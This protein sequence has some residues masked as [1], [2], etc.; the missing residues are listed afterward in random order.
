M[1][2]IKRYLIIG[3]I[4]LQCTIIKAQIFNK[5]KATILYGINGHPL[6]QQDYLSMSINTQCEY[7]RK[8]HLNAYRVDVLLNTKGDVLK[9][10]VRFDSL[11]NLTRKYNI[12]ILPMIYMDGIK[13]N[14]T[15]AY[16][17]Q[18]GYKTS[19]AFLKR[20]NQLN[21]IELGN[22]MNN[23]FKKEELAANKAKKNKRF[24]LM[25]AYLKGFTKGLKQLKPSLK[26]VIGF[27]FS[28]SWFLKVLDQHGV[29][30]D[31]IGNNF[32]SNIDFN[33]SG[34]AKMLKDITN[35]FDNR[36]SVWITEFNHPYGSKWA[37]AK[38][39]KNSLSLIY[40]SHKKLPLVKAVFI[41][42]LLDQPNLDVPENSSFEREFGIMSRDKS[43]R[44][45]VKDVFKNIIVN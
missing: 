36:R 43:G 34:Y 2:D 17:Y 40:N 26:T 44:P 45:Y 13:Y 42:E 11:Y 16:N 4:L 41:Y 23:W 5:S 7:L 21:Y 18:L 33:A 38:T 28:E 29:K 25:A 22:E 39:Q 9:G 15:S 30:F 27:S 37:D 3:I 10:K 6:N 32:Y 1:I 12:V 14:E 8:L 31:I 19:T 20:Y 35:Y 24:L